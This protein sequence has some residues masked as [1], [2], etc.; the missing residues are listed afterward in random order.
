[1]DQTPYI[2]EVHYYET[3]QMAVVHHSNY[4]RFFEEARI[5]FLAKNGIDFAATERDYGIMFPVLDAAC[6]YGKSARFGDRLQ[7]FVRMTDFTGVRLRINYEVRF[8]NGELCASGSTTL[9]IINA[10]YRPIS[11]KR[12]YPEL[13]N[14]L[15]ALVSPEE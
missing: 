2:H 8:E 4:I 13:Y 1:M 12:K 10:D 7:I 6:K 3:D 5:D 11:I 14:K 9:G 15:T